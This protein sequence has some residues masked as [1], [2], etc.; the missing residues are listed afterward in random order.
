L[1]A[2]LTT[3]WIK[4]SPEMARTWFENSTKTLTKEELRVQ[5]EMV[6]AKVKKSKSIDTDAKKKAAGQVGGMITGMAPDEGYKYE[7]V[8]G[9]G[10]AARVKVYDGSLTV[11]YGNMVFNVRA[12]KGAKA[13]E[14]DKAAVMSGDMKKVMAASKASEA[15]WM[16][17]TRDVRKEQGIKLAKVIVAALD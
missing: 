6:Q 12:F 16:D 8:A 1:E 14:I 13:P 2:Q 15:A 10:D 4:K 3:I 9:V 5:M 7:D 11:L 17:A